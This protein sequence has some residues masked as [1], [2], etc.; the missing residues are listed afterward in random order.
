MNNLQWFAVGAVL[1]AAVVGCSSGGHS[2]TP[3]AASVISS[4]ASPTAIKPATTAP[5]SGS[6]N[7]CAQAQFSRQQFT[8]DWTESGDTTIT[9][10]A[11][12]G[13]LKSHGSSGDDSGTWAYQPW[14]LTPAKGQM[15]T[16]EEKHCVLW[17]HWAQPGPPMDL[18]YVPLKLTSGSL[19]LSYIGRG[20][21]LTWV[22]PNADA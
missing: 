6:D 11:A 17:L 21:T 2:L 4:A 10:L 13:T 1:A 16:G 20:N 18:V 12:D 9:T 8:G 22:R 3:G 5:V 19:Q 15:P 14:E 7:S